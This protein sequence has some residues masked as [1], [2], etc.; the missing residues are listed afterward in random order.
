MIGEPPF[1]AGGVKVTVACESPAVAVP[2]MG[3]PARTAPMVSEM[4]ELV[5]VAWVGVLES[6]PVTVKVEVPA[7]VGVPVMAPEL[8]SERPVGR[9][10]LAR[11]K[12]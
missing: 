10:P 1:E 2:M 5:K 3:A 9:A 4:V 11:A 8:E 12:V 6:V 7:V